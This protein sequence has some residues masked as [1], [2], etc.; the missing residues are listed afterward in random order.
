MATRVL[1]V[2]DDRDTAD[3]LKVLVESRG[4]LAKN[5]VRCCAGPGHSPV[6]AA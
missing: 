1:I 3:F 6:M 4:D 5:R 2:D